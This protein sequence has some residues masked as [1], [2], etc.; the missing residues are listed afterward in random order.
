MLN[1]DCTNLGLTCT[2]CGGCTCCECLC[3]PILAH[4]VGE[5]REYED[6]IFDEEEE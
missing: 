1:L 4:I 3:E 6:D 2:E 5:I